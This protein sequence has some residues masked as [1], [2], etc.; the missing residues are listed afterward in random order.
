[1]NPFEQESRSERRRPAA[2]A[3]EAGAE[4]R[5]RAPDDAEK[6]QAARERL[7]QTSRD[8]KNTKQQIQNIIANMQAVVAAVAA[9]R[10]ALNIIHSEDSIPSVSRDK[11]TLAGLQ[12]KLQKL[13]GE[14]SGLRAALEAEERWAVAEQ[15]PAW[16][17]LAVNQEAARRVERIMA[18]LGAGEAVKPAG[19]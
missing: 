18:E 12:A 14:L 17:D 13:Y 9:I 3:A 10:A 8:I 6:K 1:M 2:E 7:E 4:A 19:K 15:F 16:G 5:E 11:K